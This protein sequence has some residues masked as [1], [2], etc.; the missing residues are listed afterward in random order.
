MCQIQI[1][2]NTVNVLEISMVSILYF[3]S[4]LVG[5]LV[6]WSVGRSENSTNSFHNFLFILLFVALF[7]SKQF[8]GNGCCARSASVVRCECIFICHSIAVE[9]SEQQHAECGKQKANWTEKRATSPFDSADF[10]TAAV[11]YSISVS[12]RW[13][14]LSG[15]RE[16]K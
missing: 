15:S 9:L 1:E 6:G 5:R 11:L 13:H 3:S 4:S 7:N 10:E 12:G 14:T 2:A 8:N 16:K